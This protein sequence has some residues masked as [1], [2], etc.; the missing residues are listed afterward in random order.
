MGRLSGLT[1]SIELL[2]CLG[3]Y[4]TEKWKLG[5][6]CSERKGATKPASLVRLM[7]EKYVALFWGKLDAGT[8]DHW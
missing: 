4:T 2:M 1:K 7:S 6:N 5:E 3:P 8:S